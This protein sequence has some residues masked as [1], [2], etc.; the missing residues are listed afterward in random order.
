VVRR[1]SVF[2]LSIGDVD[3]SLVYCNA[4]AFGSATDLGA[5]YIEI[6]GHSNESAIRFRIKKA[7]SRDDTD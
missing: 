1:L 3:A 4:R 5:I 7:S 2:V 6:H